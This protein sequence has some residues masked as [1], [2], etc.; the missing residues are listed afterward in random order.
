MVDCILFS[1]KMH[2]QAAMSW[3][4]VPKIDKIASLCVAVK[5]QNFGVALMRSTAQ[6]PKRFISC[7]WCSSELLMGWCFSAKMIL[8]QVRV[9]CFYLNVWQMLAVFQVVWFVVDSCVWK[10]STLL[11]YYNFDIWTDLDNFIIALSGKML[12]RKNRTVSLMVYYCIHRHHHHLYQSL[13]A[14]DGHCLAPRLLHQQIAL[15]CRFLSIVGVSHEIDLTTLC[16]DDPDDDAMN[17][18]DVGWVISHLDIEEPLCA[19]LDSSSRAICPKWAVT[20]KITRWQTIRQKLAYRVKYLDMDWTDL[21]LISA[22]LDI[23]KG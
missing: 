2:K 11:V 8:L 3:D 14:G 4:T 18:I 16:R 23:C 22:L 20:P 1:I 7:I 13:V 12:K 19:N 15:L 9:D 10:K 21:H 5:Y 6:K 17:D